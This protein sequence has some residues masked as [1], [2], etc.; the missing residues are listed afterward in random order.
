MEDQRDLEAIEAEYNG[1]SEEESKLIAEN[2]ENPTLTPHQLPIL[3]NKAP[4]A[5]VST[6]ILPSERKSEP[7]M[8][9]V[10]LVQALKESL[11]MTTSCTR[12]IRIHRRPTQIH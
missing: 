10:P 2:R 6:V 8:N 12:T 4:Y 9:E 3:H 5:H 11:V 7:K 1:Y